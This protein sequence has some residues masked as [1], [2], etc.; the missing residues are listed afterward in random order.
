MLKTKLA[1]LFR[2]KDSPIPRSEFSYPD[3]VIVLTALSYY[4]SGLDDEELFDSFSYLLQ[5]NQAQLKY[6]ECVDN[7]LEI[8]DSFRQLSRVNVKDRFEYVEQLFP[9]LRYSKGVI[10]YALS[11]LVFPKEMKEFSHKISASD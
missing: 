9:S 2:A 8:L 10:N 6:R 5:S 4:Y 11:H 7:A 3:I 1:V